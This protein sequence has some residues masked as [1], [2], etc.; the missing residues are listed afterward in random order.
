VITLSAAAV[1]DIV[2][3]YGVASAKIRVVPPGLSET[4][5][6]GPDPSQVKDTLLKFD[7]H[8]GF[9]L[10]VGTLQARKNAARVIAA[11]Q[12]L[13]LDL[14]RARPLIVAGRYGW[15][16]EALVEDLQELQRRGE[17]CWLGYVPDCEL[18]AL[19]RAAAALVFP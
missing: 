12:A 14:R 18:R 15:G 3:A 16:C 4:W 5:F 17:G 13:P 19:Y 10:F 11:H 2:R 7:L 6:V 8:P 9:F 1:D